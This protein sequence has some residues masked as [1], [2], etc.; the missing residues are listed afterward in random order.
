M[1]NIV[2]SNTHKLNLYALVAS[3][4]KKSAKKVSEA[5]HGRKA[6]LTNIHLTVL[7]IT[8][9]TIR[10]DTL[11]IAISIFICHCVMIQYSQLCLQY[12]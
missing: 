6:V 9:L 11:C 2:I 12:T 4:L 7:L 1:N 3:A 5:R 10:E 8:S